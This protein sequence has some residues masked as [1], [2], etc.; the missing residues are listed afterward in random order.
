[1]ITVHGLMHALRVNCLIVHDIYNYYTVTSYQ[2]MIDI[3]ISMPRVD[4]Y[5]A[6]SQ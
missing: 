2:Y 1:M 5:C 3:H 6:C 4:A